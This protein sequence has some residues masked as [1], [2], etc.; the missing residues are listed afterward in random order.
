MNYWHLEVVRLDPQTRIPIATAT[1]LLASERQEIGPFEAVGKASKALKI[2]P[3]HT[4]EIIK[5][6]R[7]PDGVDSPLERDPFR[8]GDVDIWIIT[9]PSDH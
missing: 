4:L 2:P 5:Y 7:I 9:P 6:S 3:M 1:L 8:D